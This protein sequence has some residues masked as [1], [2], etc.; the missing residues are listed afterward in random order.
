M[1]EEEKN[2]HHFE[3]L[4]K[5]FAFLEGHEIWSGRDFLK[6]EAGDN[7]PNEAGGVL[8]INADI[9]YPFLVEK[10]NGRHTALLRK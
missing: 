7:L 2:L 5:V 9:F 6:F 10:S 4:Y 8:G 3:N 1:T